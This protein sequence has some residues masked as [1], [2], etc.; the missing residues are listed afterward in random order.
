MPLL[1]T[2]DPGVAARIL[3][4]GGLVAFGTE[5]VYGL[6]ANALDATAVAKVFA[7]KGR[8]TFDPLIV[9]LS[10]FEMLGQ[11]VKEIPEPARPLMERFWPGPLTLVLPKQPQIPDLV[12]AGL[13]TVGIR[14]PDHRLAREMIRLAGVPVAAPSA[15]PFGRISPTTA[16]H[17][18]ESLGDRLDAILDAGPCRVGV[19]ST[20]VGFSESGRPAILRSGGVALEEIEEVVGP[21]ECLTAHEHESSLPMAAP[22]SLA[23]HYAPGKPLHLFDHI[24]EVP[25]GP[26]VG[27]MVFNLPVV[28]ERYGVVEVL[29]LIGSLTEAAANFF[30]ALRRLDAAEVSELYAQRLP[31]HGLGAALNDRLRRASAR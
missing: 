27:L 25:I 3:K 8:P 24:T 11:V 4:E 18:A 2:T 7:A 23:K 17:V 20:I 14:M 9:H 1:R 31:E 6:G 13:P 26:Q 19:E 15:N 28:T 29:S 30:G 16:D 12:T 5:T 10:S 21:V 22:G